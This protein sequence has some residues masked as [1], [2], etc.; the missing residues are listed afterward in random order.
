MS[1][2][3]DKS[4]LFGVILAGGSG[5][6]LWPLS[7]ELYPKPLL[8]ILGSQSLLQST[9]A[10]LEK[11][12]P[13][14]N[15]ILVANEKFADDIKLQL[16]FFERRK[17]AKPL[18]KL[19]LEPLGRNTAL[20]IGLAA[21]HIYEK[22]PE[23]LMI[24]LPS[25]HL[26]QNVEKFLMALK[27]AITVAIKGFL[28]HLG[29]I[30]TYPETGYGYLKKG[31]L[32]SRDAAGLEV[33]LTKNFYEKPQPAAAQ[34]YFASGQFLW[35][36]GIFVWQAK[37]ILRAIKNFLPETFAALPLV[38]AHSQSGAPDASLKIKE[39]YQNLPSVS[40]DKGVLEKSKNIAVIPVVFGWSDVGT[41]DKIQQVL[42]KDARGNYAGKKAILFDCD[43]SLVLGDSR[44]IATLGLQNIVIVDTPDAL[45]VCHRE[46]TER[47]KEIFETL[48]NDGSGAVLSPKF[49]E[50]PWGSW[51]VLLEGA[52]YKVKKFLVKPGQ[53]SSL[54]AHRQRAEHWVIITGEAR[55]QCDKE[56][57]LLK[58]NQSS[59]IPCQAKHRFTN[60]GA[61]ILE[62][63]E[64]QSGEYLGEDDIVRFED[65]YGR[66]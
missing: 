39:I 45:L 58:T 51:T 17:D 64:V 53:S 44:L 5:S 33:Y 15:V 52:G 46:K 65:Q 20:A 8:K 16:N 48:K 12:I 66:E 6:R 29:V 36:S 30:P 38:Y 13:P 49:S 23:A 18:E 27:F 32:F 14:Q 63:I 2:D 42:P 10:R 56:T 54:Q 41:W 28:T 22:N 60:P 61:E 57:F 26:I 35:N 11:L 19:I 40:I 55:V 34:E 3:S 59:F 37:E 1:S 9:V 50:R 21:W 47:V 31:R 24:V 4:F 62:I 7:R 25:D 43:N